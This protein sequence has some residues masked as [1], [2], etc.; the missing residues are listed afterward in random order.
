MS[1]DVANK[2]ME[3]VIMSGKESARNNVTAYYKSTYAGT[4]RVPADTEYLN[5]V[6]GWE[7]PIIEVSQSPQ[8][9]A[10]YIEPHHNKRHPSMW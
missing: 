8:R 5:M 10:V 4:V 7:V 6:T 1:Q 9:F 3:G 2:R